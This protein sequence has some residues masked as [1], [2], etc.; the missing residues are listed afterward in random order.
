M[1]DRAL[2]ILYGCTLSG[3]RGKDGTTGI[4]LKIRVKG[5]V[6]DMHTVRL[7]RMGF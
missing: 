2:R 5:R 4:G 6:K 3:K 7:H 1:K